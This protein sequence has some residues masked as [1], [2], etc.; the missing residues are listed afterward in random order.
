MRA[1]RGTLTLPLPQAGEGKKAMNPT[2]LSATRLAAAVRSRDIGCLELLD[3]YI[4][5]VERLDPRINA[6]VVRDFDRARSRARAL[7]AGSDR[8]A[9]LY[10]VPMTIKESFNV[11]GLPTTWGA[12]AYRDNIA[13][14][15]AL[16]VDR[17]LDAGVV[18]FGKTNVPLMLADYQSYNEV[19][20][21]TNSPWNVALSPGGSSGGSAAALAAGLTG[22]ETGSDIG[23]SIR[24]PAHYCG[25]Y[26]HKPTWG[27]CPPLGQSLAG[28]VSQADISVIGPLARSA[29]DLDLTLQIMAGP[30]PIDAGWKLDL[31]PPRTTSFKGL[32]VAVMTDHPLSEVDSSIT[33]KLTELA[34]FL[35]REG[36]TVSMTAR[37]D[38]DLA[39]GHRLY[40][41]MLR[42]IT[43]ARNDR[44]A[45]QRWRTEAERF[46]PG[47][48][49]YYAMM[50]R[51]V[52]MTHRDFLVANETRQRMRRKW[53][54]FFQD[55]D[56]FL[57][58]IA[59][60]PA[61]PHDH[62]GERWERSI[63]VNAHRVPATDQMFWAGI[64]CFYLLPATAAPLGLSPD[65]LPVGVQIVGAQYDD[66]TTI[67][68]AK[69]LETAWQGF[70]PPPGWE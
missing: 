30:E 12:P 64:S 7:D 43:S 4:A 61:Q 29:D 45:I 35:R 55:F 52:S 56:V 39:L 38:F 9:P 3:H 37:P 23:S 2:F 50:A 41:Q 44:A 31:P 51:G 62:V 11:A 68:V 48:T 15:N 24:N 17:L 53:A 5:R 19:Y 13:T 58:P 66:R 69:L 32:R 49:S 22:I 26:G 57:C 28:N 6:V 10:G 33:A 63:S 46:P 47:D 25:V 60:S 36:A 59:A 34:D 16:A 54:A 21:T 1:A 8:I 65:G 42:A 14:S 20:G 67:E 70:V 40:I 27:I 18:L